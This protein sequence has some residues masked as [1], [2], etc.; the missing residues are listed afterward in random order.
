MLRLQ[1]FLDRFP[2]TDVRPA[3]AGLLQ[4]YRGV[5]P[6]ALLQ[7]WAHAGP[8]QY[9]GGLLTLLDPR[10]YAPTLQG[11]LMRDRPSPDRVPVA[12]GAF[13]TLFY[14]RKLGEHAEDLAFIDPHRSG[15]GILSWSLE[16]F[17]NETLTD[18]E[19][20]GP[21]LQEV[22]FAECLRLHGPLGAGEMYAFVPALALGGAPDAAHTARTDAR[23]HLEFLLQLGR[24]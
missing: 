20:R 14:Y 3:S 18:P 10:E 16:G 19:G 4:A 12:L 15:T 6:E 5:L 22:L 2:P 1:P 8:G 13:G 7:L 23:A 21:L 17:F 24:G 11:W 9:A